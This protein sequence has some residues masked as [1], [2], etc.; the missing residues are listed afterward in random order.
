M[1]SQKL[2]FHRTRHLR[3]SFNGNREIKISRDGTELEPM[4]GQQLLELFWRDPTVL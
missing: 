3:N 1:D 4:V 2:A